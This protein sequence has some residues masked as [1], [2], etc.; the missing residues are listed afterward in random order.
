PV[1]LLVLFVFSV[2]AH[3]EMLGAN[4]YV[5]PRWS[6]HVGWLMTGTTVSC[7]PLYIL[8]KFAITPGSFVNRVKTMIR[9]VEVSI[10]PTDHALCSL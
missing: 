6:I 1:F 7:I 10:P 2:L 3:E 5:Y 8:Y 9:P 4:D